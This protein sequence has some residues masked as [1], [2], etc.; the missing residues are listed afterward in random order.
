MGL[1]GVDALIRVTQTNTTAAAVCCNGGLRFIVGLGYFMA[2]KQLNMAVWALKMI[3][4]YGL[5]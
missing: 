1:H 5:E 3:V 4:D 2:L